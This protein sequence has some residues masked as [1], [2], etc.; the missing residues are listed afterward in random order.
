MDGLFL[1]K[2]NMN[3]SELYRLYTEHPLVATDTRSN[4]SGA[5]FFALRGTSFNG[6][7]FVRHALEQ[8][9]AYCVVDE[10]DACIDPRAI[11]VDDALV[12]LQELAARHRQELKIPVIAITGTNGKTTTKE[13]INAVLSSAFSTTCTKGNLNNHIGVPLTLLSMTKATEIAIVEMGANHVGEIDFLCRIADPGLGLITNVGKAHL[14]GF[15]SFEG[16]VSTKT[17][18]YR[19]LKSK[20]GT[21]FI[22]ADDP[23]LASYTEGLSKITYGTKGDY[24][25]YGLLENVAP[26]LSVK[27][28]KKGQS[29]NID[30]HLVGSYN[31]YNVLAAIG[32]G[33]CF[34]V[35]PDKIVTALEN[36]RPGNMRSQMEIR[37]SNTVILDT[38]NANPTS[39]SAALENFFSLPDKAKVVVLGDML[40]LGVYS[41]EEHQKVVDRLIE[42]HIK[43]A[44]LVGENFCKTQKPKEYLCFED[45]DALCEYFRKAP[46]EESLL[47]IKGSRSIK[48]E[49]L[50]DALPV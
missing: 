46:P 27:W 18:L 43:S 28:I 50:L 2:K 49:K 7:S 37:G 20:S 8:G 48:L 35:S 38:Y 34:G 22:N 19:Y 16:V 36:Y 13:L 14:E 9:A 41:A 4:L 33:D 39:M 32:V 44:F 31:L 5:I 24:N 30:T 21:I 17:E 12:A 3:I 15:G 6:N 26:H 29:Y 11:L 25:I 40:E 1:K 10:P 42:N 45:A 23:V 47:L